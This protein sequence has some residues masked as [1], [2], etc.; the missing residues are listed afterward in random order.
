MAGELGGRPVGE[1]KP[2]RIAELSGAELAM[3]A[4]VVMHTPVP[5]GPEALTWTVALLGEDGS[6]LA[7]SRAASPDYPVPLSE[8]AQ[9]HL[10]L[11][12][13]AQSGGWRSEWTTDG[14]PRFS[15]RVTL[16]PR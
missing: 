13:L 6:V 16:C 5:G 2:P 12:G 8:I 3:V 11:A 7:E 1:R 15:A 4:R 9:L 10:D 14:M